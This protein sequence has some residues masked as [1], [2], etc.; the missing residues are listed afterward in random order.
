MKWHDTL[1][2][3][4]SPRRFPSSSV[5]ASPATPAP[6]QRRNRREDWFKYNPGRIDLCNIPLPVRTAAPGG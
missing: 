6:D 5:C 1:P 4:R 3:P 2:C